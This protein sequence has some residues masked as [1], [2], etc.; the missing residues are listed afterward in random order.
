MFWDFPALRISAISGVKISDQLFDDYLR[1]KTKCYLRSRS[2]L[3]S[4]SN[5]DEWQM[6]QRNLYVEGAVAWLAETH[7][8]NIHA[9]PN[10]C[11]IFKSS[12]TGRMI[13]T[14]V[15][16]STELLET[17]VQAIDL[18]PQRKSAVLPLV[19]AFRFNKANKLS[20]HDRR[21]AA[22]DG[23]VLSERVGNRFIGSMIVH[24]DD[25]VRTYVNTPTL[26]VEVR[27][28]IQE[29]SAVLSAE[30]PPELILNRHCIKCE[31]QSKCQ[32]RA[33]ENDD[34]SL[35]PGMTEKERKKL[36]AKGIF[37]STQ[38]SY[39]YRPRRSSKHVGRQTRYQHSLKALS[40]RLGKIHLV[41]SVAIKT[42]GTPVYIDVEGL[43][44]NNFYYLTGVRIHTASDVIQKSFWADSSK[45]EQR[46]WTSFLKELSNINAPCLLHYGA[47]EK[48]FFKRMT[49]R[50][51][52]PARTPQ[53][54]KAAT[55]NSLNVLSA[56]YG[57]VYF[58]TRTNGLKQVAG[59]L[60]AKWRSS[61]ASGIDSIM[62]RNQWEGSRDTAIKNRL[63]DYNQD[64]CEA[65]HT[66][67][68]MLQQLST[69]PS[70]ESTDVGYP[71][72]PK[73]LETERGKALHRT[74]D[75]ILK[76]A[77]SD[78]NAAKVSI[79]TNDHTETKPKPRKRAPIKRKWPKSQGREISVPRKRKCPNHP[80]IILTPTRR[81][82]ACKVLDIVFTKAGCRKTILHY[83]GRKAYCPLCQTA[84]VPPTIKRLKHTVFGRGW[85]VWAVYQRMVLRTSHRLISQAALDLF[86]EIVP[87]QSIQ[88]LSAEL[89][90][91][92]GRTEDELYAALLKSPALHID[93]TQI[94]IVGSTQYVWVFTDGSNV[95]FRL[96]ETR[97]AGFLIPLLDGYKGV[98]ISDFYAGYDALKCAQ[99]KCIVHLIRDIN[100]D[101]WKHPFNNELEHFA[102]A[103]RDL[104]IPI[105]EDVTRYGSKARNL[106]KHIKRVDT[107]Y[108]RTILERPTTHEIIGKYH[109]RFMRYRESLF[110]FLLSDNI[111]WNNN[112]AERAIR[113]LAVQRKISG[114]FTSNGAKEYLRM[115]GISQ[116]CRFQN[117]S[118]LEF[119]NS[120][121]LSLA[122]FRGGRRTTPD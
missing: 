12:I 43:P 33:I 101:L 110:R 83:T 76:S 1:C 103:V 104:L 80:D 48:E 97:E 40:L 89:S 82:A 22:F 34:L 62:W 121:E 21:M 35:L 122:K 74:F 7:S 120:G 119:L 117:K 47:Y 67:V 64:D 111:P 96:T 8:V 81:I 2:E 95:A 20:R 88:R 65:L 63:V 99:Q 29:A 68:T 10:S 24:G 108:S 66:L 26:G 5:Y 77:H 17:T 75:T 91:Q 58:P 6:D 113:H 46:M 107:F 115:L 55:Q 92:Y 23:L 15:K 44:G 87:P 84:Y 52:F 106:R 94:N 79:R 32:K 53:V 105:F 41:G 27:G 16:A 57:N 90:S 98:V 31:F 59:F 56:M 109:K 13:L 114:S 54:L 3:G 19:A 45:D 38:L 49:E 18:T 100:D 93:E 86:G 25:H 39:T 70:S 61:G 116:T 14:G 60:G 102:S 28:L 36:H 72:D 73:K 30:E 42:P 69:N 37:T 112:A 50:Y 78:F 118:F 51:G 9:G 11:D 71:D 85:Q 4:Q